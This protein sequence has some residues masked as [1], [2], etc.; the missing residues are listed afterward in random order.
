MTT[1]PAPTTPAPPHAHGTPNPFAGIPVSDYVRDAVA[2][3]LLLVSLSMPWNLDDFATR[4]ATDNIA[5]VLVTVLSIL[6]LALTYLAR[7][8]VFGPAMTV[9]TA[10][11]IRGAANAP[12]ALVVAIYLIIDASKG[13]DEWYYSG[14]I[15]V[16]AAFGLAGAVLAGMP[17]VAESD[18]LAPW[19]VTVM[20]QGAVGL[21]ALWTVLSFLNL[22]LVVLDY[23]D[24]E[25]ATIGIVVLS[26]LII[27]VALGAATFGLFVR[28]AAARAAVFAGTLA[29]FGTAVID[30][31]TDWDLSG[32]GMESLHAP[33]FSILPLITLGA[34]VSSPL[35]KGH[36]KAADSATR[37]SGAATW[38]LFAIA[39]ISGAAIIMTILRMVGD[40]DVSTG[41]AIGYIVTL[42]LTTT[43]ALIAAAF[44]RQNFTGSRMVAIAVMGGTI[45]V[46]VISL[47]LVNKLGDVGF[48]D[49]L[50]HVALPLAV[51]ALLALSMRGANAPVAPAPVSQA[52]ADDA[53]QAA[54][55]E[56]P[57]PAPVV[58]PQVLAPTTEIPEPPAPASEAAAAPEAHPRAAE[59]ADPDTSAQALHEIATTIP[60]LRPTVAA[61]PS[62]YPELLEW[63]GKLGEPAVDE[64]ISKRDA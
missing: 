20:Q 53:G 25:A 33:V 31:M 6:S 26:V 15:G 61:N 62:A 45:L 23:K 56:A 48:L 58:E 36:T 35:V 18:S 28:S 10:A 54:A 2:L 40:F 5:V 37:D 57:V 1:E 39:G 3:V 47:V 34:V 29:V 64:A 17:R 24:M 12:Y 43:A 50:L 14:G 11:L 32:A 22:I 55:V 13:A 59:A 4:G 42:I 8:Q 19:Q 27:L 46:G 44:V 63:M 30:W 60:E 21:A 7:A 49:I 41:V 16:A 38:L 51:I 52:A 9:G